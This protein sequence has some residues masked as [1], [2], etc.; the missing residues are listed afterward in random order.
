MLFRSTDIN[1]KIQLDLEPW[2]SVG[3][4][5]ISVNSF[6]Y[7]GSNAHVILEETEGYLFSRDLKGSFRKNK[8]LLPIKKETGNSNFAHDHI[9]NQT[10]SIGAGCVSNHAHIVVSNG[11]SRKNISGE[12]N[13]HD[14][15]HSN[16]YTNGH[17]NSQASDLET[18]RPR[19]F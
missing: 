13:G 16:S 15:S 6:G 3:S 1:T 5:R 8:A 2:E 9:D 14:I 4:R 11:N 19:L 12:I 18:A 10:N 17:L 7:G